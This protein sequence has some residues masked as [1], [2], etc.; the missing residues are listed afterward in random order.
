MEIE[1]RLAK[2]LRHVDYDLARLTDYDRDKAFELAHRVGI[3][4][5]RPGQRWPS[6]LGADETG[7]AVTRI[8]RPRS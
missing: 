4:L 3:T 7:G 8:D 5:W 2:I 6:S 1:D